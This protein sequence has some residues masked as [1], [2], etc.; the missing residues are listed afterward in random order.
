MLNI[1]HDMFQ[2]TKNLHQANAQCIAPT[3]SSIYYTALT[4][5]LSVHSLAF[6]FRC[7]VGVV[8]A[9]MFDS[10][11]FLSET[12]NAGCSRSLLFVYYVNLCCSVSWA[13]SLCVIHQWCLGNSLPLLHTGNW[14][15]HQY[16]T[17]RT[18]LSWPQHVHAHSGE[19]CLSAVKHADCWPR[20]HH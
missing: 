5:G 15:P 9:F 8:Q 12:S 6:H 2:Y 20:W 1:A 17:P 7:S 13:A 4:F 16:I 14:S 11:A 10:K 3:E 19:Y 18:D